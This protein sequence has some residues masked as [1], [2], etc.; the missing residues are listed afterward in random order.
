MYRFEPGESCTLLR[1]LKSPAF[2]P[3]ESPTGDRFSI[4]TNSLFEIVRLLEHSPK[5]ILYDTFAPFRRHI[6]RV[7]RKSFFL[8]KTVKKNLAHRI[9]TV[10]STARLTNGFWPRRTFNL[11]RRRTRTNNETRQRM[12]QEAYKMDA[13]NARGLSRSSRS[14]WLRRIPWLLLP[15]LLFAVGTARAQQLTGTI[16]GTA[17]DQSDARLAGAKVV[18][19]NDSSGDQRTTVSDKEGFFSIT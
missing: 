14:N 4:E 11:E 5:V 19:K 15:V 13:N 10:L 17:V 8:L 16:S 7:S 12:I 6:L 1:P 18:M 9:L 3:P 2:H